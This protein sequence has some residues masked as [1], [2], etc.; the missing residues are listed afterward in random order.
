MGYL[1]DGWGYAGLEAVKKWPRGANAITVTNVVM[2]NTLWVM[3]KPPLP[4]RLASID[5]VKRGRVKRGVFAGRVFA[6]RTE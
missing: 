3:S 2:G 1:R 6:G 5:G 4:P